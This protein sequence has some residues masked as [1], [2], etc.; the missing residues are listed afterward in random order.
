[1]KNLFRTLLGLA[2]LLGLLGTGCYQSKNYVSE[3]AVDFSQFH[4]VMVKDAIAAN[5]LD[6]FRST[7]G[8]YKTMTKDAVAMNLESKGFQSVDTNADL[9]VTPIWWV[10]SDN[11]LDD[12][13]S[14]GARVSAT[15]AA[16]VQSKLEVTISDGRTGKKLW[17]GWSMYPVMGRDLT[18][19]AIKKSVS[20]ALK[21]FP[22]PTKK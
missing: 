5:G 1:M 22:P 12:W 15:P 13:N 16:T 3:K 18:E 20:E 7:T 21:S 9:V 2:L 10:S 17:R 4:T 8:L 19:S 6:P 11:T 14:S